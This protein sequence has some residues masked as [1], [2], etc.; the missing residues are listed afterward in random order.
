MIVASALLFMTASAQALQPEVL[1]AFQLG[2]RHPTAS[3]VQGSDGNF[4]GTTSGGGSSDLGTVFK[5][6]TNGVWTTLVSFNN[7]NGAHPQAGL[8]LG[9]DG[10]LY[11]TTAS[12]GTSG[13]G[14]SAGYGSV[15]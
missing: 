9:N 5:V 8:V 7:A 12:Y 2:P 6:T 1:Y 4:Y 14:G 15:L 10:N 3:L 13:L 11:G